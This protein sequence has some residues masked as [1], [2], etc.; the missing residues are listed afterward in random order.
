MKSST[1]KTAGKKEPS[2]AEKLVA[3]LACA[4]EKNHKLVASITDGVAS[5]NIT[6]AMTLAEMVASSETLLAT[7]PDPAVAVRAWVSARAVRDLFRELSEKMTAPCDRLAEI[8]AVTI[9]DSG[10]EMVRVDGTNFS[11]AK[12]MHCGII[13]E[14]KDDVVTFL[15]RVS[16]IVKKDV[17]P[18]TLT[19]FV[20]DEFT[21]NETGELVLPPE[22]AGKIRVHAKLTIS[23]RKA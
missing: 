20:E 18:S 2:S 19:K 23:A 12:K 14:H 3:K 22:L 6:S 8:A 10:M 9:V 15:E 16:T 13:A 5:G 1:K 4:T 21:D 7:G 17:H 11:P